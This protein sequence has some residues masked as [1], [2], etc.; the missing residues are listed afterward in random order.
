M[1]TK[2]KLLTIGFLAAISTSC[3]LNSCSLIGL[4]IG[5]S[6][7]KKKP[8]TSKIY[9]SQIDTLNIGS[10]LEIILMNGNKKYGKYGGMVQVYDQHF[11]MRYD[12]IK[13]SLK[14]QVNLPSINDTILIYFLC[15]LIGRP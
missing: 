15:H 8:K 4:G 13:N 12:S 11:Q 14:S 5:A 3:L 2:T 1:K 10:K 9:K 7:D 6:I